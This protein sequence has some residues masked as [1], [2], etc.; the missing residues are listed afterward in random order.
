M[1]VIHA[2]AEG[3]N[4]STQFVIRILSLL[5]AF[6]FG[7]LLIHLALLNHEHCDPDGAHAG[8]DH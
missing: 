1:V 5:F 7:V 4:A 8:H 6:L 2:A 3:E